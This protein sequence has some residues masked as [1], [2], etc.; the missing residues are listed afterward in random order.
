MS[1]MGMR[2]IFI[3]IPC[4]K[5]KFVGYLQVGGGTNG[6]LGDIDPCRGKF[7]EICH[8]TVRK[9]LNAPHKFGTIGKV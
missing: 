3:H 6:G 2:D 1:T 4:G 7:V 5:I 8:R 9:I